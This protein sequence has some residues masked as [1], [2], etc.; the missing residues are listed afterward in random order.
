VRLTFGLLRSLIQIVSIG[1]LRTDERS[2]MRA[3]RVPP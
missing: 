2:D 3:G 1:V